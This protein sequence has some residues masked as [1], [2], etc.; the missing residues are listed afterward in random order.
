MSTCMSPSLVVAVP[1]GHKRTLRWPERV[2]QHDRLLAV[3]P[4]RDQV[5]GHAA[6]RFD[7]CKVGACRGRQLCVLL[8][9]DRTLLPARHLLVHRLAE[10]KFFGADRKDLGELALEL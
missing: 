6:Q 7:P 2:M 5:D 9:A 8:D 10:V 1:P 3:R 4:G